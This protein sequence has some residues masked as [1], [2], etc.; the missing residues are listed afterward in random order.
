MKSYYKFLHSTFAGLQGHAGPN[1]QKR[2][3]PELKTFPDPCSNS[4]YMLI[5][6]FK[7]HLNLLNNN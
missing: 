7:V 6:S 2:R 4:C 3:Y 1:L 5:V